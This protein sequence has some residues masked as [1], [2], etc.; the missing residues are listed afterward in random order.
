MEKDLK[1][2]IELEELNYEESILNLN[3][4]FDKISISK[5]KKILTKW[6]KYGFKSLFI[7][8]IKGI[9]DFSLWFNLDK[10]K[11]CNF[12]MVELIIKNGEKIQTRLHRPSEYCIE[13]FEIKSSKKTKRI[14]GLVNNSFWIDLMNEL[15]PLLIY[16]QINFKGYRYLPLDGN[17]KNLCP[18]NIIPVPKGLNLRELK[19]LTYCN[20]KFE[21]YPLIEELIQNEDEITI[22]KFLIKESDKVWLNHNIVCCIMDKFVCS[23]IQDTESRTLKNQNF[24]FQVYKKSHFKLLNEY[25]NKFGVYP[26]LDRLVLTFWKF[27][28]LIIETI[29]FLFDINNNEKKIIRETSIRL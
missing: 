5:N 4:S 12:E 25:A 8:Q 24:F 14:I 11:N 10:Y 9:D 21:I 22:Y 7:P 16:N 20:K 3:Q 23:F 2:Y 19:S 17:F 1:T 29:S 13:V 27:K 28:V 18:E 15:S 6:K 26:V